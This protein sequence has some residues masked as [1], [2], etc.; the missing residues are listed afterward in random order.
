MKELDKTAALDVALRYRLVSP[1]TNWLVIDLRAD[2]EKSLDLP[3]LRKVPQTLAAGWGGAGAISVNME[4]MQIP[5]FCRKSASTHAGRI[6]TAPPEMPEHFLRLLTA[7]EDDP[8]LLEA[9]RALDLLERA[10]IPGELDAMLRHTAY[11]GLK[12]DGVAVIILAALLS[13]PLGT[14]LSSESKHAVVL[15]QK[16]AEQ[17]MR[18][19][20]EIGHHGRQLLRVIERARARQLL[21]GELFREIEDMRGRLE[22]IP[23]FLEQLQVSTRRENEQLK[24][25][26]GKSWLQR[27]KLLRSV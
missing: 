24:D 21:R 22:E 11:L 6:R 13:G 23:D 12:V 4:M 27:L 14:Y 8:S 18:E 20:A 10:G 25:S 17:S 9:N 26:G 16:F 2:G 1:W 15:L 19:L 3:A 7:I 5:M